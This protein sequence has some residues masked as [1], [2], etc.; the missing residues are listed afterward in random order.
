MIFLLNIIDEYRCILT[1]RLQLFE[2][3]QQMSFVSSHCQALCS[4]PLG[5]ELDVQNPEGSRWICW[6]SSLQKPMDPDNLTAEK[7]G[8]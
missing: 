5:S 6:C 3:Q 8:E 2:P 1:H 7:I 4:Q